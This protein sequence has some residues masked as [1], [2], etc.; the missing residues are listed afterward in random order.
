[1][2]LRRKLFTIFGGLALLALATAGVTLWAIAQWQA[3]EEKLQNH[4]QRSLLL[5][6]VR[7]AT[8]R[9]T[10]EVSDAL[11]D[12]DSDAAAEFAAALE[13]VEQDFQRWA[14]LADS[15]EE[16]QQV[17]QIWQAHKNLV[18]DA[19]LVFQLL[20]S[21][22]RQEAF[23][24]TEGRLEEVDFR[25]FENLTEQAVA[26]DQDYR[27]VILAQT[28][29]TRQTEQ[30]VLAIAAFGILSLILLLAAYL[31]S[32]LFAPLRETE[33]A[34]NEVARGNLQR[35]LAADR[36]DE[37]GAIHHAFN[38]MIAAIAEREQVLGLAAISTQEAEDGASPPNW[39]HIPSRLTL[40]TLVSQLRSRVTQLSNNV[41]GNGDGHSDSNG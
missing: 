23:R 34:L 33:Q 13:P 5:Q 39:Q 10:R 1:M 8:F 22:R 9:A 37:L 14:S 41:E 17:A 29:N 26:S 27:K 28:Q 4:Y 21:G 16:K 18:E 15:A 11:I 35:R 38:R 3:T 12:G 24:L 32:D 40:H 20:E 31:A 2:N 6:R 25:R 7:A 19:Q 36:D 30:L